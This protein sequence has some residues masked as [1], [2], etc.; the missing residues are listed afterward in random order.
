MN[1][2]RALLDCGMPLGDLGAFKKDCGKVKY[3]MDSGGDSGG[4]TS[5]T[6]TQSNIPDWARPY[7]QRILGQASALTDI[8]QNPYQQYGGQRIAGFNPLQQQAFKDI[9]G[10][11][12]SSQT[13]QA[14][15]MA[16]LAG[17]GGLYAGQ[18]YQSQAADPNQISKLMSPYQQNVTDWQK[19]QAV[20]DYNRQSPGMNAQAIGQGAFGGSRQAV[21]G[22]EAQRNLQNQLAG[23]QASGTQDAFRNAQQAQQFG[24][25]LGL[26]GNQLAAQA[27]GQLGNLGQDDY[28]QRMGINVAQQQAGSDQRSLEQQKLTE[29]YADF[30]NQQRYPYQQLGFMSDIIRGMPTSQSSQ[31]MYS[32]PSNNIGQTAGLGLAAYNA[33]KKEGGIIHGYNNGG[34]VRNFAEGG[35][36]SLTDPTTEAAAKSTLPPTTSA[37]ALAKFMLPVIQKMHEPI[38]QNNPDTVA[39]EM[40]REILSRNQPPQ[41]GMPQGMPQEM[42]QEMAGIA[43]LPIN[44]FQDQNYRGGGIVAFRTGGG[45]SDEAG[46]GDATSILPPQFVAPPPPPPPPDMSALGKYMDLLK[47]EA[48]IEKN[49]G[50]NQ[51]LGDIISAVTEQRAKLGVGE[52]GEDRKKELEKEKSEEQSLKDEARKNFFI[53]TGLNMAAEASK[54]G[55]PQSGIGALLQPLSVGAQTALPGLIAEQE[56]LRTLAAARNA[57]MAKIQESRRADKAGII[58]LS[59]GIKDKQ[60][61]RIEKYNATILGIKKD[62]A[63]SASDKEAAAANRATPDMERFGQTYLRSRIG[64]GDK[65]EPNLILNEGYKQYVETN[66]AYPIGMAGVAQRATAASEATGQRAEASGAVNEA[67]NAR[68]IADANEKATVATGVELKSPTGMMASMAA[69]K[70][71][72]ENNAINKQNNNTALPTNNAEAY[73]ESVFNRHKNNNLPESLRGAAVKPAPAKPAPAQGGRPPGAPADAVQAADKKWYSPDP[74]RSGKFLMW[75]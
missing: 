16:G 62:I 17:L 36:A 55:N 42:P 7:A 5:S 69:V 32:A 39:E 26:Q 4:P 59:Q 54:K 23:I 71:D 48:E 58:T 68:I 18:N 12:V 47:E 61:A 8:N 10:M 43:N 11:Q 57:E 22:A 24:A 46:E 44:N 45:P 1:L 9:Q 3:Y 65:R 73:R 74:K 15:G 29:Q 35:L 50:K 49:Q 21:A 13:G 53:S 20:S 28:R 19:Q 75:G 40:A 56:K 34:A 63:K 64:A 67:T 2:K 60:D 66:R 27:A 14:S 38:A 25:N 72:K 33:F 37:M 6:I 70:K 30:Q 51:T 52:L 31:Q 41:Q